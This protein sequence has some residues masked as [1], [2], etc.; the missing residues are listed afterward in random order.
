MKKIILTAISAIA[1]SAFVACSADALVSSID[2]TDKDG[3]TGVISNKKE[4]A[5]KTATSKSSSSKARSSSSSAQSSS[6]SE[7]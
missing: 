1:F 3:A 6:S 7:K 2:S 4:D 5:V